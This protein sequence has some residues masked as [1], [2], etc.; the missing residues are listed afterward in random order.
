MSEQGFFSHLF[1]SSPWDTQLTLLINCFV[2]RTLLCYNYQCRHVR[3]QI[4]HPEPV[5]SAGHGAK[6][7]KQF[8][9]KCTPEKGNANWDII[10]SKGMGQR[11]WSDLCNIENHW[12]QASY[13]MGHHRSTDRL[14][15]PHT[16]VGRQ[17][18]CPHCW[19]NC[20]VGKRTQ[21]VWA[22]FCFFSFNTFSLFSSPNC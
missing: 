22:C 15:K 2:R 14:D 19:R 18:P 10:V 3:D 9:L 21:K 11:W 17:R 13:N 20:Y 7:C 12:R 8:N 6:P 16:A 1:V 5:R 4:P